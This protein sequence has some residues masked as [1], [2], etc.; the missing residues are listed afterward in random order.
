MDL[1]IGYI[2]HWRN[3]I[4]YADFEYV[5]ASESAGSA[6]KKT[7][8]KL[9]DGILWLIN[10][11]K[12]LIHKIIS[13]IKNHFYKNKAVSASSIVN[14]AVREYRTSISKFVEKDNDHKETLNISTIPGLSTYDPSTNN[15]SETITEADA[16]DGEKVL[17]NV[18]ENISSILSDTFNGVTTTMEDMLHHDRLILTQEVQFINDIKSLTGQLLSSK[19]IDASVIGNIENCSEGIVDG[20]DICKGIIDGY[21]QNKKTYDKEKEALIKPIK[22][23]H[24]TVSK[25][26]SNILNSYASEMITSI[27]NAAPNFQQLLQK[28]ESHAETY[29][30]SADQLNVIITNMKNYV[31]TGR[32]LNNDANKIFAYIE[33]VVKSNLTLNN[34]YGK[35]LNIARVS[36]I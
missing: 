30:K 23:L 11:V 31:K 28:V 24:N 18:L 29:K 20:S 15:Q 1:S 21:Q 7:I 27:K 33:K 6:I 34:A 36:S 16:N 4:M 8:M 12:E 32:P 25:I 26:V 17:I 10:K 2:L 14:S 19:K 22:C 9:F 35:I 13:A 3:K 5:V